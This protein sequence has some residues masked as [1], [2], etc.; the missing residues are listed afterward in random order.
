MLILIMLSLYTGLFICTLLYLKKLRRK[1]RILPL[2][3]KQL[4]HNERC[5]KKSHVRKKK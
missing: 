3:K 1:K 4:L 2:R 5:N